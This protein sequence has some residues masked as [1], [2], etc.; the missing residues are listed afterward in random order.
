MVYL[1]GCGSLR[2]FEELL[3]CVAHEAIWA[4]TAYVCV[5]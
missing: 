5:V 2:G 3:R 4:W 1:T